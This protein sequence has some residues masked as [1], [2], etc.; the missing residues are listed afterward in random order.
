MEFLFTHTP[1][2]FFVQDFWRDEAFSV[3]LSQKDIISLLKLTAQDFNPPL[4]YLFLKIWMTIF[5]SSEIAVRS[6]SFVFYWGTVYVVFMIL[7]DMIKLPEK[8]ASLYLLFVIFNPLLVFYAFE[9]RMYTMFAFFAALSFY[10]FYLRKTRMYLLVTV[11]GLFTHYFMVLALLAQAIFTY[12]SPY[13]K[14]HLKP[15]VKKMLLPSIL[16]IVWLLFVKTQKQTIVDSFWVPPLHLPEF[17]LIPA[18]IYT[19]YEAHL[20]FLAQKNIF[21]LFWITTTIGVLLGWGVIQLKK[22]HNHHSYPVMLFF[23]YWVSIPVLTVL[24]L[25]VFKP[26]FLPR[27]L[28]FTVIG[29]LIFLICVLEFTHKKWKLVFILLLAAL[30]LGFHNM[31]MTY[32]VK[33]PV[34]KMMREIKALA[35]Q[36]DVIYVT[37]E[38]DYFT[39]QYYFDKDRVYVYGKTYAEIPSFVGKALIPKERVTNQLPTFPQKAFVLKN[40]NEYDIQSLY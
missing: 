8:K 19:G 1:L 18:Y 34:G 36:N 10:S 30:T 9:G 5:G 14:T 17:F 16:F 38:L 31:Q 40:E 22:N 26:L 28:I 35:K 33:A 2:K 32:R 11:L 7:R 20:G 37:N 4:Y 29:L 3:L 25:S 21:L 13:G 6:L 15:M 27:Y 23:L 24:L 39:A 12:A